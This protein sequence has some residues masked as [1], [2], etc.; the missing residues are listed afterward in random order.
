MSD[1]E[2]FDFIEQYGDSDEVRNEDQL[3]DNENDASISVGEI[4]EYLTVSLFS[5]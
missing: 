5:K 2:D 3:P 1:F 4:S